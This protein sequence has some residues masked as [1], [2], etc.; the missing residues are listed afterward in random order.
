MQGVRVT[1]LFYG[2]VFTHWTPSGER[3]KALKKWWPCLSSLQT[4][5][6][7]EK[8]IKTMQAALCCGLE[9]LAPLIECRQGNR[10][11]DAGRHGYLGHW[12]EQRKHMKVFFIKKFL[13]KRQEL[14]IFVEGRC[15]W[16]VT[17]IIK[18]HLGMNVGMHQHVCSGMAT[19]MNGQ[20][21]CNRYVFH[22]V[23]HFN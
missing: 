15:N 17:P 5:S 22:V 8:S 18:C 10:P 16:Y 3:K 4:G 14:C 23:F 12:Q 13:Y 20:L 19:V 2:L 21:I 1:A 9:C 6:W 7:T 11:V